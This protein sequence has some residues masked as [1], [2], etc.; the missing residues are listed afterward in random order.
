MPDF[1]QIRLA[2]VIAIAAAV[3]GTLGCSS[4]HGDTDAQGGGPEIR[5]C[6]EYLQTYARCVGRLSSLGEGDPRIVAMRDR[7]V[8]PVGDAQ[9]EAQRSA[10]VTAQKQLSAA[11]N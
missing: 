10:C 9:R 7:F 4:H 5:E 8:A 1:S 3:D 6:S 2:L 11:C